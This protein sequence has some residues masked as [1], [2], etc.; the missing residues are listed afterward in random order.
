M[1]YFSAMQRIPMFLAVLLIVNGCVVA[2]E[3]PQASTSVTTTLAPTTTIAAVSTTTTTQVPTTTAPSAPA[4]ELTISP[5]TV[6][7]TYRQTFSGSTEPDAVVTINDIEVPVDEDGLF[8]L[9]D[10]WNTPGLNTVAVSAMNADGLIRSLRVPYK[11]EPRDGWVAII[12]DSI[13]RGATPELE[14]RFGE[15]TVQALSGRRFDEGLPIVEETVADND[16]LELLIIGLGSNGPVQPE[17]FD[18]MMRLAADVPRVAFVNVRVDRRWNDDSNRE[19]LAGVNRY[20]NTMIIDWFSASE[21]VTRLV[22]VDRVHPTA[23]G[24]AVLAELIADS[25][26]PLWPP[27][28]TPSTVGLDKSLDD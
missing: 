16:A 18:E 10:W 28:Y 14:A 12:G 7:D 13:L 27:Q 5:G 23:E 9:A 8:T 24:F 19:L 25:V 6:V 4:L 26:F 21:D 22:R 11:F 17:D 2:D 20:E 3:S 1:V 15:D